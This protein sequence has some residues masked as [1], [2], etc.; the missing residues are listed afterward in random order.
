MLL[1]SRPDT[2]HGVQ[3]RET[4]SINATFQRQP[5]KNTPSAQHHP[6]Y[7]GL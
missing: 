1:R 6:Y 4:R 7:S 2:V 3:L 5:H